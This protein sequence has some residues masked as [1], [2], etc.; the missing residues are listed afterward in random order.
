MRFAISSGFLIRLISFLA[1]LGTIDVSYAG[2]MISP[3]EIKLPFLHPLFGKNAILQADEKIPIWGWTKPGA[4]VCLKLKDDHG[5]ITAQADCATGADG[6]WKAVI[7]PLKPGGPFTLTVDGPSSAKAEN[8]LVGDLWLCSGQSN[9]FQPLSGIPSGKN[10]ITKANWPQLRMF[11]ILPQLSINPESSFRRGSWEICNPK[12][13]KNFSAVAYF[14]G[15]EL[16]QT[17]KRPVG[18][19]N[20]S[21]GGTRIEAWSNIDTL[22]D[23]PFRNT[24]QEEFNTAEKASKNPNNTLEYEETLEKW[25]QQNDPGSSPNYYWAREKSDLKPWVKINVPADPGNGPVPNGVLW[26]RRT[27]SVPADWAGKEAEILQGCVD[28]GD[29]NF[30]FINGQKIGCRYNTE[31]SNLYKVPAGVLKAGE[32]TI[33]RRIVVFRHAGFKG[34]PEHLWIRPKGTPSSQNVSLAGEWYYREGIRKEKFKTRIPDDNMPNQN[35]PGVLFN[36]M[37][38]PLIP[39]VF[40]GCIWY[41]GEANG[42]PGEGVKY[43]T[44]LKRMIGDW[45]T[46]FGN[47]FP[48]GI[49]QLP[50]FNPVAKVPIENR[51]WNG[52]WVDVRESQL[53]VAR[54]LPKVGCIATIDLGEAGNIHP[55]RKLEVGQRLAG[56]ALSEVYG[57]RA[58]FSGPVFDSMK[59]EGSNIRIFFKHIGKGLTEKDGKELKWFAISGND[60]KFVFAKA[61]IEEDTVVVSSPQVKNPVA[62]RYAWVQNPGQ[63]NFYNRNGFP[64]VPFKTDQ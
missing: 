61:K 51:G 30:T 37:I 40:K 29:W 50:N 55:G 17:L 38:S 18:L 19:I 28:F 27:F 48:F 59:I 22:K 21:W 43:S 54:F 8:I 15:R 23:L 5:R 56:W 1:V 62:V 12:T 3:G 53:E 2:F 49:V 24:N 9:M 63:V 32:N 26:L 20:A 44:Y 64:A 57:H 13:V 42:M 14:F 16:H 7:G 47:D 45:R 60:K 33:A 25:F 39:A 31:M 11:V 52:S 36:G 46:K 6:R 58:E 41:Q 4:K 35:T 10:E 34:K